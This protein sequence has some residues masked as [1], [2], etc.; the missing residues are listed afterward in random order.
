MVMVRSAAGRSVL[1][2]VAFCIAGLP[3][4]DV[5]LNPDEPAKQYLWFVSN[6]SNLL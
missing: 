1:D 4:V 6:M 3:W 5:Y 2:W